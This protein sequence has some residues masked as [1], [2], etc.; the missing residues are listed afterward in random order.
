MG[1]GKPTLWFAAWFTLEI[2]HL[3]ASMSKQRCRYRVST[4]YI[5]YMMCTD[6][7]WAGCCQSNNNRGFKQPADVDA[8]MDAD[9]LFTVLR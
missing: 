5:A 1:C 6:L 3:N 9:T 7:P 2:D 8:R 4:K